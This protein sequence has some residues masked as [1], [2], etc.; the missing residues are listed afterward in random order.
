MIRAAAMVGCLALLFS[1]GAVAAQKPTNDDCL[2]CHGTPGLTQDVNGKP[3]DLHVD[4]DKFKNSM[5]GGMFTCVDCHSDVKASPHETQPAR[6]SC[7]N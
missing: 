7:A 4:P 5:H 3:V 6:V 2:A 1:A